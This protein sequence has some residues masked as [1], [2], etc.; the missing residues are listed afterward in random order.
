MIL[1]IPMISYTVSPTAPERRALSRCISYGKAGRSIS[2]ASSLCLVDVREMNNREA[3]PEAANEK[4]QGLIRALASKWRKKLT[5]L[6]RRNPALYFKTLKVGTLALPPLDA[7]AM[8]T[9]V[10]DFKTLDL[11][12]ACAS[13]PVISI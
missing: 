6:D 1:I 9:L 4:L 11:T 5:S 2:G 12:Q 10:D 8:R 13:D 3:I 7:E